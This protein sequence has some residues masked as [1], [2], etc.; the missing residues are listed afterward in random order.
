[1]GKNLKSFD[2]F[3]LEFAGEGAPGSVV[4]PGEWY[5]NNVNSRNY[6]PVGKG[7]L[8]QVVDT[9]YQSTDRY[10]YLNGDGRDGE[11]KSSQR[12]KKPVKKKKMKNVKK[13]ENMDFS[14][15]ENDMKDLKKMG[16]DRPSVKLDKDNFFEEI[17]DFDEIYGSVQGPYMEM[18]IDRLIGDVMKDIKDLPEEDREAAEEAIG[19][20]WIEKIR[21]WL[22][23]GI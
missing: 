22:K 8:P 5:K 3:L 20:L 7:Q 6:H 16:F 9:L 21:Y 13:F 2:T 14:D 12:K 10:S 15:I 23:Y 19:E 17:Q 11:Y 18:A 4:V 1:M